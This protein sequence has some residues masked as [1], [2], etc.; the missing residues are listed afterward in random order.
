LVIEKKLYPTLSWCFFIQAFFPKALH[1][2][3]E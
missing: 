3:V 1:L 2:C